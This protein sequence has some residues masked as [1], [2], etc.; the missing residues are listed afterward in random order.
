MKRVFWTGA[1][2]LA[3]L[4]A[5]A[6]SSLQ[7]ALVVGAARAY[8][9]VHRAVVSKAQS[10]VA[11]LDEEGA[12]VDRDSK[13]DAVL[14]M[15]ASS[16]AERQ[17]FDRKR[18]DDNSI[19]TALD[20]RRGE[21]LRK[22]RHLEE[23]AAGLVAETRETLGYPQ[24]R[25]V[26]LARRVIE[27]QQKLSVVQAG[28]EAEQ[29]DRQAQQQ[30]FVELATQLKDAV[31]TLNSQTANSRHESA[32]IKTPCVPMVVMPIPTVP[33]QPDRIVKIRDIG[34]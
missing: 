24:V 32:A 27:G 2:L 26:E 22:V 15:L 19:Q 29:A 33:L 11:R 7:D 23:T 13:D 28:C 25:P 16:D 31:E 4:V 34:K 20:V 1:M 21:Q 12:A 3:V 10:Q 14:A 5:G 6:C 17:A 9:V 8:A 18:R 30:R